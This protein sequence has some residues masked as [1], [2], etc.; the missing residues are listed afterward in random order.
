[1]ARKKDKKPP[2]VAMAIERL[3]IFNEKVDT[4][5][6]RPFLQK[7]DA[8]PNGVTLSFQVDGPDRRAVRHGPDSDAIHAFTLTFRMFQQDNDTVSMR[9][10]AR[11]Y[12]V[13]RAHV[14][15]EAEAFR[16]ARAAARKFRG[17]RTWIEAYG[18]RLTYDRILEVFI[19]GDL[20]HTSRSK[21]EV[22]QKWKANPML[23]PLVENEFTVGMRA[24]YE[25][26]TYVRQVN[27]RA[28]EKLRALGVVDLVSGGLHSGSESV[29]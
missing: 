8:E 1:M 29:L 16:K 21:R 6:E 10:M 4:L 14:P 17:E 7:M 13:L 23:Y 5:S 2:T 15:D 18:E 20:A 26:L 22:F 28:L 11:A 12:D 19:Y 25:C 3:T 9:N 24:L 27:T